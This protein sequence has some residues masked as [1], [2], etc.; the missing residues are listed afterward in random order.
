MGDAVI[1]TVT[2][3]MYSASHPSQMNKDYVAAFEK[4]NHFRPNFMS[5]GGYDGMHLIYEALKKTKGKAD[6]DS[7]VGAIKGMKWDSPR[8]PAMIDPATR[9]IVQDVYIR[10]VEKAGNNIVNV[11]IDTV[12]DVKDP[13][14]K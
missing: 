3:H 4:A 9:D 10:K 13:T 14:H 6:G 8:G 1:G 12:K 7:L 11:V 5:V 2:A